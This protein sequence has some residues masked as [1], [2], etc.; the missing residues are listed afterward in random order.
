MANLSNIGRIFYG[1]ALAGTGFAII[2]FNAYPYF[3]LLPQLFLTPGLGLLHFITGTIFILVGACIVFEKKISLVSLI[4]GTVL[5]LI[6]C[7]LYIPYQFMDAPKHLQLA[8][9][10]NA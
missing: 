1:I 7:F 6:F 2:Y 9:W 10:E 4:F 5:L 8:E 3:F